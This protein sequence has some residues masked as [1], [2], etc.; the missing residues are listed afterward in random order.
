[1]RVRAG[2]RVVED[3]DGLTVGWAGAAPGEA[4]FD[5]IIMATPLTYTS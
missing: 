5:A 2:A 1:M 4:R 3:A